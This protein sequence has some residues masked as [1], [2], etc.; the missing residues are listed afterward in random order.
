MTQ[1]L[2]SKDFAG[3][4]VLKQWMHYPADGRQYMG[5]WGKVSILSDEEAVGFKVQGN[6][7]NWIARVQ[8]ETSSVNILG[9]QIRSIVEG[10][11]AVPSSA[12]FVKVM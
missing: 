10:P 1:V 3:T 8:G 9:C 2:I 6:E 7:S 12:D 11:A 4:V 5:F